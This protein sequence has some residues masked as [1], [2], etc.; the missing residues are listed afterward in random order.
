MYIY[1]EVDQRLVDERVS[2]YRG[3]TQRFIAGQ[4]SDDQFRPL[5]LQNGLYLQ[6]FAPMLRV[7]IPYGLL[8]SCQLRKLAQIA[9]K[10]DRGYGHFSTRQNIQYNWPK[11]EEVPE[12]LAELAQV[13]MHAIQTSGSCIRN[14]TT[15]HFAG[16][17]ADEIVD[18]FVWCELIRQWSTFHPEFAHLPRKFKIAA[19]V[20]GKIAQT[21]KP[22]DHAGHARS[23]NSL[24]PSLDE[25]PKLT[26][27]ANRPKSSQRLALRARIVLAWADEPSNKA[28][29]ARLGVC[30]ATVGTGRN[31][32]VA[33]RLDG[34]ADDPRPGAPRTVTDTEVER[35]VTRTRET[36]PAN[37]THGSTRTR[38]KA[39]GMSQSAVSRIGR[40]FELKPHRHE[41]FQLSTDPVFV[42]KVR[43]VVG[44]D[45][46]P[47]ENAIVLSVDETSPVQAL[48]RTQPILPMTPGQ[49]ER[50]TH[51]SVRHGVT[52]LFA[53]LNVAT[54]PVIGKCHRRHR[55]QEFL[56]FLDPVD[57]PPGSSNPA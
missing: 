49:A 1:D 9:R 16:V 27:W 46:A 40:A 38:A 35:V 28:V 34:L 32:F 24:G 52:S 31:R 25:R 47:P 30:N 2:Q 23:L 11:L 7:A 15:D 36:K 20:H 4:L 8:S 42:E 10:Y 45:M 6:R 53:A 26:T 18:S 57:A 14:I 51:D 56:K 29:A 12:I 43:D 37:A 55:H 48:A 41:T 54:S 50:G 19:L 39:A 22:G 17:A 5:R 13:Q 21:L 44:L 3:Q 33:K